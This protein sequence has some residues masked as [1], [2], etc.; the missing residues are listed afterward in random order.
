MSDR[1]RLVVAAA[2][3][4]DHNHHNNNNNDVVII[5]DPIDISPKYSKKK[6]GRFPSNLLLLNNNSS[7]STMSR[8]Y[9]KGRHEFFSAQAQ[10]AVVLLI[11]YIGDRWPKS[12]PRND[13]HDPRMFWICNACLLVAALVTLKREENGSARGIQLLSRPQTEEWKGWMQWAFILVSELMID[14]RK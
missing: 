6:L 5:D 12:Y 14:D 13:N 8:F 2:T 7:I 9:W 1:I 11:A 3:K 4:D 10:V